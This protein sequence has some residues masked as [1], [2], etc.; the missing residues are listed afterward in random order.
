MDVSVGLIPNPCSFGY[1]YKSLWVKSFPKSCRSLGGR[2]QIIVGRRSA[3]AFRIGTC[4][5]HRHCYPHSNLGTH[6]CVSS[7]S[8]WNYLCPGGLNP[9]PN[10]FEDI[11]SSIEEPASAT[12]TLTNLTWLWSILGADPRYRA[13]YYCYIISSPVTACGRSSD[14]RVSSWPSSGVVKSSTFLPWI[15]SHREVFFR[16]RWGYGLFPKSAAAARIEWK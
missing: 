1:E 5:S 3:T 13:A 14:K 2:A 15:P 9:T 10:D 11:K 7:R 16:G 12:C 4:G 6:I 8:R